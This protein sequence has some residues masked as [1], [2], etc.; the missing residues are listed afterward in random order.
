MKDPIRVTSLTRIWKSIRRSLARNEWAVRLLGLSSTT[1]NPGRPGLILV[2]I[3]GLSER[4]VKQAITDGNMRFLNQLSSKEHY[5]IQPLYSGL[6][7]NTSA[8]QAELYYGKKCTVPA[9]GFRDHRSGKPAWMQSS[10][11]ATEL[12][13]RLKDQNPGL[14]QGGSSYCNMY[15]GGAE[16]SHFCATSTGWDELFI[17]INPLRLVLVVLMYVTVFLRTLGLL[18]LEV[19]LAI[20]RF[21]KGSLTASELC[22]EVMQIPAHV[23]VVVLLRELV[24]AGASHDAAR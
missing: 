1:K 3:D 10:E 13:A 22:Q 17:S 9:F 18:C 24:V 12:E 21:I 4:Q 15:G 5:Q 16:E 8:F 20:Y 7:S 2:Q 14:I 23:L 11:F 19:T 6:P